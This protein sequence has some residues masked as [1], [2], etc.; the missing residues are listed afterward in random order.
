MADHNAL[1]KYLRDLNILYA[2]IID[3]CKNHQ[4]LMD[5]I[6]NVAKEPNLRVPII[7]AVQENNIYALKMLLDI[8][9]EPDLR[10]PI[11]T[12]TRENYPDILIMLRDVQIC[13][14]NK[15]VLSFL[16][17]VLAKLVVSF[18]IP[19]TPRKFFHI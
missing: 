17:D 3:T 8:A 2:P 15:Q 11:L 10:A 18:L 16:P 4:E 12:A 6:L 1:L 7:T 9:K 5:M 19:P 13:V 14:L